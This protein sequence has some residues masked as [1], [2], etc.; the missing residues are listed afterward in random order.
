MQAMRTPRFILRVLSLCVLFTT[1]MS[2]RADEGWNLTSADF[3]R[4]T[5]NLKAFDEQGAKVIPFGQTT[6]VTIPLDKLLQLD[7]GAAQQQVRGAWTLYLISGDRVGGDPIS[8][9][10]DNLIWKSPAA[11]ELT[12]P[13][14]DLKGLIKGQES[15]QFDPNRTEDAV[16]LANGMRL[17]ELLRHSMR[18]KFSVKQSGGDSLPVDLSAAKAIHFAAAKGE[19]LTGPGVSRS[20]IGWI[21]G[22]RAQDR[23]GE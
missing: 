15:P 10:N 22:D 8:I 11:G 2:L 7:R 18:G 14:K 13:L 3:K 17:R 16:F 23:A 6:E 12:I 1:A 19:N 9:A 20:A 5:V 4:T 21:G